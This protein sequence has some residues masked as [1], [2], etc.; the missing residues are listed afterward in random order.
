MSFDTVLNSII[1]YLLWAGVIWIFR[2]P[3]GSFVNWIKGFINKNKGVDTG[4]GLISPGR[5]QSKPYH[6]EYN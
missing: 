3:L 5:F 4:E 1:P 6:I 2:K